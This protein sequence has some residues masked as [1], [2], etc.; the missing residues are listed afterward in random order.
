MK[1]LCLSVPSHLKNITQGK[2]YSVKAISYAKEIAAAYDSQLQVLHIIEEKAHPAFSLSGKSSIFDLVPNI[3]E[4]S[5]KK[6]E[7]LIEC[8]RYSRREC[9]QRH[10]K[11]C[12]RKL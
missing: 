2:E 6:I 12:F 5:R 10:H 1:A 9:F 3:E 8:N 11:V 7:K 4:E